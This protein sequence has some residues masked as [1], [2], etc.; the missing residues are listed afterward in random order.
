MAPEN[1]NITMDP[2][3]TAP[4]AGTDEE[5]QESTELVGTVA[6]CVRLNVREAPN[7][8]APVICTIP[9]GT[10]VVIV[11]DESTDEFYAVYTATGIDGFCMKQYISVNQ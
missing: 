10:E 6:N 4:V 2:E 1:E 11:E 7:P 9:R 8:T 3:V 5:A